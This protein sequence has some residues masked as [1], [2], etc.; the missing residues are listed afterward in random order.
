MIGGVGSVRGLAVM[1]ATEGIRV[2]LRDRKLIAPQGP[3]RG[4][5]RRGETASWQKAR[6]GRREPGCA[7]E[8]P[9]AN[10]KG[11]LRGRPRWKHLEG[12]LHASSRAPACAHARHRGV[13]ARHD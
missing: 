11:Q 12:R 13:P 10:G 3:R 8:V 4:R 6:V 7:A 9:V 1:I 2:Y 5:H